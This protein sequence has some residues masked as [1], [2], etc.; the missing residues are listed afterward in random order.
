MEELE[1]LEVLE[2]LEWVEGRCYLQVCPACPAS[3][4][5]PCSPPCL[6]LQTCQA[7]SLP[8]LVSQASLTASPASLYPG[9]IL[10]TPGSSTVTGSLEVSTYYLYYLVSLSLVW[11]WGK[12][13]P[14]TIEISFSLSP[15]K[16]HKL[17]DITVRPVRLKLS[18]A[19]IF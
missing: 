18:G 4:R 3:T 7:A 17:L 1:V 5:P 12:L 13:K 8:S 16:L 19:G 9:S 10:S 15:S 14:G 2:V 6:D 11:A